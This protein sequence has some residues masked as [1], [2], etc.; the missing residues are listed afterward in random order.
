M[1]LLS[2]IVFLPMLGALFLL[3]VPVPVRAQRLTALLVALATFLISLKLWFGFDRGSHEF[4]FVEQGSWI[5]Q[6][7]ISYH[8]GIDGISI[9]LVL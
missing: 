6:F 7:G 2:T 5:P 8:L 9:L 4:Q 3:L 1:P